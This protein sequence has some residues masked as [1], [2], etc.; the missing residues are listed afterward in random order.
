MA[1]PLGPKYVLYR[2]LDPL[3]NNHQTSE[4]VI[5]NGKVSVRVSVIA[6]VIIR[7]RVSVRFMVNSKYLDK[8]SRMHTKP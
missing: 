8:P 6:T 1:T 7:V 3:G 2:Y 5:V 4:I